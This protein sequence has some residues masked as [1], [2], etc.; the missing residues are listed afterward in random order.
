VLQ[1][2][3]ELE[4]KILMMEN[5]SYKNQN[6]A[7]KDR[8]YTICLETFHCTSEVELTAPLKARDYKDPLIVCSVED[9]YK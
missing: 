6:D 2:I 9:D 3:K 4:I 8:G 5:G 1:I 7:Q